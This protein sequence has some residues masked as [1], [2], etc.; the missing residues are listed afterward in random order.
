MGRNGRIYEVNE[1]DGASRLN[2]GQGVHTAQGQHSGQHNRDQQGSDREISS[3]MY[4]EDGSVREISSNSDQAFSHPP[5]STGGGGVG[6]RLPS[7]HSD[8]VSPPISNRGRGRGSQTTHGE[9]RP[10][11]VDTLSPHSNPFDPTF[12]QV[13]PNTPVPGSYGDFPVMT[14]NSQI[15]P[16]GHPPAGFQA[17]QMTMRSPPLYSQSQDY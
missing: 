15:P 1:T 12:S 4:S 13:F 16:P 8:M 7:H 14:P 10:A 2:R 17:S 9:Q 5:N 3:N 6:G 11:R